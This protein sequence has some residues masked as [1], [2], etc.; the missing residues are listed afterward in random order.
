MNTGVKASG[1]CSRVARVRRACLS[2]LAVKVA[3]MVSFAA[4][5][6]AHE[7]DELSHHWSSPEYTAEIRF[8][9][10]WMGG[11]FLIGAC[12]MVYHW[13]GGRRQCGS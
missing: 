5:A 10:V 4:P 8:Q 13:F 7:H 2:S 3:L 1:G 6:M 12:W 9:L 11:L